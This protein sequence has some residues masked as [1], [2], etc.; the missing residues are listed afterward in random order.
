VDP[1]AVLARARETLLNTSAYLAA[2][3]REGKE[4]VLHSGRNDPAF[5]LV[6]A[7]LQLFIQARGELNA[8]PQRRL[9]FY[10]RD[11]LGMKPRGRIPDHAHLLLRAAPGVGVLD[12]PAGTEF[13]A[14]SDPDQR[15]LVY[16]TREAVSLTDAR[17]VALRVLEYE[18]DPLISP[19]RELGF[20]TRVLG[21]SA[22]DPAP[23]LESGEPSGVFGGVGGGTLLSPSGL[24][25]GFAVASPVLALASGTR[26]LTFDILLGDPVGE[27]G[28]TLDSAIAALE[29]VAPGETDRF[30]RRFGR[31]V[32]RALLQRPR[33]RAGVPDDAWCTPAQ[34]E[35]MR[36]RARVVLGR[37]LEILLG[38]A[39][40]RL[41]PEQREAIRTV[42]SSVGEPDRKTRLE[43][44][45]RR[46][47][48]RPPSIAEAEHDG[49]MDGI[50]AG[51]P[52]RLSRDQ[53]EMLRSAVGEMRASLEVLEHAL[54]A[55]PLSLLHRLFTDALTVRFTGA[56]GWE[57]VRGVH[58]GLLEGREG[59]GLRLGMTLGPQVGPVVAFDPALHGSTFD[60][61]TPI[62]GFRLNP[63]AVFHPF[64]FLDCLALTRIDVRVEVQGAIDLVVQNGLG[65]LDPSRPFFPFGPLPTRESYLVVGSFEAAAKSLVEASLEVEWGGLPDLPGGLR[66]HYFG[67]N[68]DI[69]NEAFRTRISL[70]RDG[71]WEPVDPALAT[72]V[73]LFENLGEG[74]ATAPTVRIPL[75]PMA[76]FKPMDPGT[77]RDRFA[78][79]LHARQGLFR[80]SLEPSEV[81]FGHQ[82]YPRLL[83]EG[84]TRNV[85]RRN[86]EPLPNPPYTPQVNRITL[87]YTAR[88]TLFPER[89]EGAVGTAP[90][91]DRILHE[92]PFG[93]ED[94]T[95]TVDEKVHTLMPGRPLAPGDGGEPRDREG[96]IF[97]GV[98]GTGLPGALSLLFHLRHDALQD[99][100]VEDPGAT[101]FYLRSN[102]WHPLAASRVMGDTTNGFQRSGIVTLDIPEDIDAESTILPRGVFWLAAGVNR[103]IRSL[104][105]RLLV[106]SAGAVEVVWQDRGNLRQVE[107]GLPPGSITD[108]RTRVPGLAS[109]RQVGSTFGGRGAENA[110]ELVTRTAERLRHRKRAVS[111][112]DYER[113]V[114]DRFPEVFQVKVLPNTDTRYDGPRPGSVLVV[115]VPR[116]GS[117]EGAQTLTPR[118]SGG[119][120]IDI[121]DYL[122]SLSPGSSRLY[123][124]NPVYEQ[125]Q[126]RCT[127]KLA[128]GTPPG[129]SLRTLSDIL[130]D[131]LSPWSPGGYGLRFGW[132]IRR[133]DVEARIRAVPWVDAVTGSPCS[134]S[135]WIP[136][137]DTGW[138]IRPGRGRPAPPDPRGP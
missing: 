67:Y 91:L 36:A 48:A 23:G 114:L 15:E 38:M 121:R 137:V 132:R 53:D 33:H 104:V 65:P 111:A 34:R 2:A 28:S 118:F 16:A 109:V 47:P 31:I 39:G 24:N 57:E 92:H 6:V 115:V 128:R 127:V 116:L 72:V 103:R 42:A 108:P 58:V 126:V 12:L 37:D 68:Q 17:V 73:P 71:R 84:L 66:Q 41:S 80:L 102:R 83:T 76:L 50:L 35:A 131:H 98:K 89:R 90:V 18:R 52:V 135:R 30:F 101:W 46:F 74:G 60:G 113:L 3:G 9:D 81:T 133:K 54:T 29:E 105:S 136:G 64:S 100:V 40:P 21:A 85:R 120:L 86:P 25:L 45:R 82:E 56:R 61:T 78:S 55:D 93:M 112:W 70:L 27:A 4:S 7:F 8:F 14:G 49:L 117:Q 138:T 1:D 75:G 77:T 134:R 94:L 11:V 19:E 96:Y 119:D 43:A 130:V 26:R 129:L 63:Q 69:T 106:A 110:D 99:P 59:G 22:E 97:I 125:I 5:G 20:V 87:D 123:V 79:L 10:Y 88:A 13:S 51:E 32:T 107:L 95:A 124:Q 44:V 62:V 122:R